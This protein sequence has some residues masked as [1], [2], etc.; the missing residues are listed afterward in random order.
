MEEDTRNAIIEMVRE[1]DSIDVLEYLY[2]FI[3]GKVE[4]VSD[5]ERI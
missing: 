1:I 3:K 4:S 5:K 2:I